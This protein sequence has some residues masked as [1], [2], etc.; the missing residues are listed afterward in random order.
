MR[1][2]EHG[3][4]F[5]TESVDDGCADG[6]N[7][8]YCGNTLNRVPYARSSMSKTV[9]LAGLTNSASIC[10]VVCEENDVADSS[11]R[12][13]YGSPVMTIRARTC[14]RR[15]RPRTSIDTDIVKLNVRGV[16]NRFRRQVCANVA[17]GSEM[18]CCNKR[19]IARKSGTVV[20]EVPMYLDTRT[21]GHFRRAVIICFLLRGR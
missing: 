10:R 3:R 2:S 12:T 20:V 5:E 18:P 17:C 19:T 6:G 1:S 13:A 14:S 15:C 9:A 16:V 21:L 4:V 11:C 8:F 7:S